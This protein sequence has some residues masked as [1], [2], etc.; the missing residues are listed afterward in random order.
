VERVTPEAVRAA[1]ERVTSD[2]ALAARMVA[3]REE[4]RSEGGAGA[5]ADAIE[6]L[7]GA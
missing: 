2:P 1:V 3:L 6:A 7:L 4:V 5:A